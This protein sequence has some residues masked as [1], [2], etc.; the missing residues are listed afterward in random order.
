[1]SAVGNIVIV[2]D[3]MNDELNEMLNVSLSN[4]RSNDKNLG[5]D[6]NMLGLVKSGVKDWC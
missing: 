4:S 5:L 2:G 6:L 1:L 3:V